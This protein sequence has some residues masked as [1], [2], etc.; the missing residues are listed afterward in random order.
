MTL[1][2]TCKLISFQGWPM[3]EFPLISNLVFCYRPLFVYLL[4]ICL[5]VLDLWLLLTFLFCYLQT[6]L[7]DNI[8]LHNKAS[9]TFCTHSIFSFLCSVVSTVACPFTLAIGWSILKFVT[10][11]TRRVAHVEQEL[12]TFPEHLRSPLVFIEV[13]VARYLGCFFVCNVL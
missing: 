11:V 13:R 4:W 5:F 7:R 1:Q 6:L 8:A 3:R 12:I 2:C 10:K 9:Y